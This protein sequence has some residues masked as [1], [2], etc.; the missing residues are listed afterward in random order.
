MDKIYI[1]GSGKNTHLKILEK[2]GFK[3]AVLRV[4]LGQR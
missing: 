2:I 3:T 4:V 1:F